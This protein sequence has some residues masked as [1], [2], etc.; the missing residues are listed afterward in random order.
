[1]GP[2]CSYA[3]FTALPFSSPCPLVRSQLCPD[4]VDWCNPSVLHPSSIIQGVQYY[5]TG[6]FV[7]CT[8]VKFCR[9]EQW[10]CTV[11]TWKMWLHDL[12]T[13]WTS[14]DGP[15]PRGPLVREPIG[16][17]MWS[18]WYIFLIRKLVWLENCSYYD[19]VFLGLFKKS[20]KMVYEM[21]Q[22]KLKN[23]WGLC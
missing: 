12:T 19:D 16:R 22:N 20:F 14:Q 21:F 6:Q 23:S 9:A 8:T 2:V 4:A 13:W 10:C 1:M 18:Y 5:I 11:V 15:Q 3:P 7:H 17:N